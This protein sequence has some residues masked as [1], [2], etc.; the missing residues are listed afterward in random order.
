MKWVKIENSGIWPVDSEEITVQWSLRYGNPSK[1]ELLRAAEILSAYKSLIFSTQKR[2][3]R[4]C[5]E[6]R[7]AFK[8]E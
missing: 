4:V 8:D 5:K 3:N 7:K 2:R 1:S 6:L